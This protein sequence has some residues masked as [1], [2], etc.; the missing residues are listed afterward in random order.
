MQGGPGTGKTG[1]GLH[2]AALS[3]YEHRQRLTEEGALVVGPNPTFLRYISQVLPSLG[4][5]SVRQATLAGLVGVGS[6]PDVPVDDPGKPLAGWATLRLAVAGAGPWPRPSR[7]ARP[8]R[9]GSS[10]AW[11]L[12]TV[13]PDDVAAALAEIR[14]RGVNHDTSAAPPCAPAWSASCAGPSTQRRGEGCWATAS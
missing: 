2:R 1:R 6:G 9:C 13:D 4:E 10:T 5:S 14:A 11:G 12:A 8:S 7:R 3:L